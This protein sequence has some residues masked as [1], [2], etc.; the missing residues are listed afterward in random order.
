MSNTLGSSNPLPAEPLQR[1]LRRRAGRPGESLRSLA[2]QLGVSTRT[3]SR[4]LAA[5][6]VTASIADRLS[7]RLHTHPRILWP[8][9]WDPEP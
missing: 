6:E 4:T 5:S 9:H 3:L 8:D 7:I 2:A 1:E